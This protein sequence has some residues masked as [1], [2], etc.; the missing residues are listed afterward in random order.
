[1][2]SRLQEMENEER[3]FSNFMM[4]RHKQ[5]TF[6][7]GKPTQLK[8]T[9]D[10]LMLEANPYRELADNASKDLKIQRADVSKAR[11][12][13][14]SLEQEHVDLQYWQRVFSKDMKLKLFESACPFLDQA[15]TRHLKDLENQQLHVQFSTVKILSTG[16]GKED[17]NV[18]CWNDTG[19]EGFDSLSGGEQQMVSFAIG[20]ALADLARSQTTGASEF[21]ILDEPF[22]ML[23]ERNSEAIV[24]Y[25]KKSMKDGTVL[26]VSN[27][28]QLKGLITNRINVVKK[29]GISEVN[30]G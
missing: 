9:L 18:R 8:T 22:S 23:D 13:A 16:E 21:Q 11:V 25:L 27:E 26:L 7:S 2:R 12:H 24:N 5:E 19:G 4:E 6:L 14:E 28:D 1:M 10:G 29:N 15:T 30:D 3:K 20:R 17:F